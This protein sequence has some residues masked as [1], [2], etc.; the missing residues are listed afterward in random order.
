MGVFN[1]LSRRGGAIATLGAMLLLFSHAFFAF[2]LLQAKSPLHQQPE[3]SIVSVLALESR[4]GWGNLLLALAG[5][6]LIGLCVYSSIHRD[7]ATIRQIAEG[8]DR[9]DSV[10]L[11][12]LLATPSVSAE[13]GAL[14]AS[15]AQL[16]GMHNQLLASARSISA[17]LNHDLRTPVHTLAL[18]TEVSLCS[19]R[20]VVE[21]EALLQSNLEEL[22]RLGTTLDRTL[23][24]LHALGQTPYAVV[25]TP[26]LDDKTV[27]R[28]S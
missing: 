27:M 3:H 22:Q 17:G 7:R 9:M 13:F 25:A 6:V 11:E 10:A 8:I 5:A 12:A 1:S 14:V 16:I 24:R 15:A 2:H 23:K 4:L 18:Q 28:S 26:L 20:T 19:R 21:Y